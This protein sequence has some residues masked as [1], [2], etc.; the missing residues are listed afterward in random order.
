MA[1][2][3][4]ETGIHIILSGW[5]VV[6]VG[7]AVSVGASFTAGAQ[8]TKRKNRKKMGRFFITRVL[9]TEL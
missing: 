7:V 9:Q 8:A 1:V 3:L 4:A 6:V 5:V 2:N